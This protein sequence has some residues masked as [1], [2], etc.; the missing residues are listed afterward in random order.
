MEVTAWNN[1]KHLVTGAGYGFKVNAKDRDQH[2]ERS[3]KTVLVS[4][5]GEERDVDVNIEKSSFW[6]ETCHE[7]INREFGRW[8]LENGY[9]PWSSGEPPKFR[10][11]H[12]HGN[13]FRL[14]R[15]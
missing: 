10:L 14:E 7:L 13:H 15:P 8:L 3:W 2:F 6:S 4:L 11:L 9:A 5:P 12:E 1:G